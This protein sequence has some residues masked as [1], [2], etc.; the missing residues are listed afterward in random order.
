MAREARGMEALAEDYPKGAF[1]L[2][3][4]KLPQGELFLKRKKKDDPE[5]LAALK[6]RVRRTRI[7]IPSNALRKGVNALCIE[8]HRTAYSA[9]FEKAFKKHNRSYR[10]S[11]MWSTCGLLGARLTA[12]SKKGILPFSCSGF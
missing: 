2:P 1:L 11:V 4:G 10:S 5:T 9:D 6:S 7:S 8:V 3:D 12:E